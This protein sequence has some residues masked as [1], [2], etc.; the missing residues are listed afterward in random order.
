MV[1]WVDW[2]I[3]PAA[4]EDFWDTE[5]EICTRNK[6]RAMGYISTNYSKCND[7]YHFK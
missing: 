6:Q 3:P 5:E 4:F 2:D 1:D 7:K